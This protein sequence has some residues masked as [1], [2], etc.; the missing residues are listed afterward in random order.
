MDQHNNSYEEVKIDLARYIR[1]VAKR[2]KTF[3]AV[4]LLTFAIGVIGIFSLPKIYRISMMI[5]P[6]VAGP[7][8]TGAY[9]LESAENLKGLIVNGVYNDELKRTMGRD[10]GKDYLDFMVTIP[11]KTNILQVSI[12]MEESKKEFGITLLQNL[13]KLLSNSYDKYI[14]AKNNDIANEIKFNERAMVNARERAD[15]LQAQIKEI[16][17][18]EN[19]LSEEVK[20]I[21]VNTKQIMDNREKILKESTA[22]ESATTLLLANYIQNNLS[23]L[24]QANNQFSDLSIRRINLNLELKDIDA[25]ISA[26]QMGIDKLNISKGFISNLNIIAQPRVSFSPATPSRKKVLVKAIVMGLFFGLLAVLLQ[27]FLANNSEK[28]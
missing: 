21:N 11:N 19:K 28:K 25:Q 10:S 6:P 14:E 7:S 20:D 17:A 2:K 8:F 22:T 15:N 26:L 5:Q 4:F 9:D 27:E 1:V 12:D 18:R 13:S 16:T 23:Y 24:N 3:I